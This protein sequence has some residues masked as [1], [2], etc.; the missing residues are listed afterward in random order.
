M[1]FASGVYIFDNIAEAIL[2]DKP[3]DKRRIL[4]SVIGA[5]EDADWDTHA[6]S[7]FY[8][9]PLVREVLKEMHPDWFEDDDAKEGK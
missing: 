9:N 3:I 1:G 7:G 4:K 6:D 2:S 5:L 8:E